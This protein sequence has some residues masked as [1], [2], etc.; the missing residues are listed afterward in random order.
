MKMKIMA[1]VPV[2][3][4]EGLSGAFFKPLALSYCLAIAASTVP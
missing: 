4:M 3:F 1:L 2:F